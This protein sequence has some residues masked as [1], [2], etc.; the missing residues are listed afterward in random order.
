[1]RSFKK[2]IGALPT[3]ISE[4]LRTIWRGTQRVLPP[5]P[6]EQWAGGRNP[7][8]GRMYA[9]FSDFEQEAV[10][11]TPD[12]VASTEAMVALLRAIEHVV[13]HRIPGALVECGVYTG[14]NIEL[15][16][17][18]LQRLEIADRHI[19]AYD[20]FAGMPRP[21]AIDDRGTDAANHTTWETHRTDADGDAGSNWMR[22][23]LDTVRRRLSRLRYPD[24]R[25]H[26]VQGLVEQTIPAVMPDRI[27]ILRLDTDFYSSTKHELEHLYP[28]LSDGGVLIIDDYGAMPGCRIATDEYATEHATGWFLHRVDAHVRLTTKRSPR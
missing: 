24:D 28:R 20:T 1:M 18:A 23:S 8:Q 9:D 5:G 6:F 16:I 4:R 25:L 19:Y 2:A 14:G 10:R 13:H 21:Q 17:R 15:M 22:A 26:F 11:G 27:A 3:P 7:L 12:V